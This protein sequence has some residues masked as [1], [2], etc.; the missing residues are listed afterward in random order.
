MKEYEGTE[1]DAMDDSG[2]AC[3]IDPDCQQAREDAQERERNLEVV[4]AQTRTGMR[5]RY[6]TAVAAK[7]GT[8][9]ACPSCGKS[10][11]KSTYNKVFCSNGRTARKGQNNCKDRYWNSVDPNRSERAQDIV[12]WR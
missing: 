2:Y 7:Q 5:A 12:R 3:E 4:M 10:T 9:F 1:A 11:V 6:D 8:T